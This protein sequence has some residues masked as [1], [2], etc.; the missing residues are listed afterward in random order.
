MG[1]AVLDSAP[2]HIISCLV[3]NTEQYKPIAAA[4]ASTA[5]SHIKPQPARYPAPTDAKGNAAWNTMHRA[6]KGK[7]SCSTR[8]SYAVTF[9]A[10]KAALPH[11]AFA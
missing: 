10:Q 3:I 6:W 1:C 5:A 8:V 4:D 9:R 11:T 2:A 7:T